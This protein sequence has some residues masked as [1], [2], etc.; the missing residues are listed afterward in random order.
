MESALPMGGR[1]RLAQEDGT[2]L[3]EAEGPRL[4]IHAPSWDALGP[5]R[6]P[7]PGTAALVQFTL[8]PE[9]LDVLG[10]RI[11]LSLGPDRIVARF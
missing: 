5:S 6:P 8:L 2:W 7:A 9:V 1:I 11:D 10:R 3:A 4:R